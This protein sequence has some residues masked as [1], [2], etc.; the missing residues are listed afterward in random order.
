MMTEL[1][2]DW[3]WY[4]CFAPPSWLYT[5]RFDRRQGGR[6]VE[7]RE[8][9]EGVI[10]LCSPPIHPL[11]SPLYIILLCT[12]TWNLTIGGVEREEKGRIYAH[13][14]TS[15]YE[16]YCTVHLTTSAAWQNGNRDLV[17]PACCV[18]E[19]LPPIYIASPFV[20]SP[21]GHFRIIWNVHID[22]IFDIC[23]FTTVL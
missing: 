9:G 19:I 23:E 12:C 1:R 15:Y 17:G 14:Y 22:H 7:T 5:R 11:S 6:G 16:L 8:G 21:R 4:E 10:Y 18:V 3:D 20:A 2:S 13:H